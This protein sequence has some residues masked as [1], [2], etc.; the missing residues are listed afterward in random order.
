VLWIGTAVV[1]FWSYAFGLDLLA[2][3]G[4]GGAPA[5][6]LLVAGGA[7]DLALGCAMLVNWRIRLIATLQALTI[8]AYTAIATVM[9][10]DLRAHP[11][12]PLLKNV[13]ILIATLAVG[14]VA[15]R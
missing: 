11:F 1:S 5:H 15:R 2:K 12:G 10:P 8:L 14:F 3:G 4:V 7:W 9:M 6:A 13:P